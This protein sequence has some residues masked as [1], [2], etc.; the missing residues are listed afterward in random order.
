MGVSTLQR[1][2]NSKGRDSDPPEFE[3]YDFRRPMTLAREHARM[4]EMAFETFARQWS[5]QLTSRLRVVSTIVLDKLEMMSYDDYINPL[6]QHTTMALLSL[7][8]GR[9]QSILQM[10][11]ET[12]LLWIDYLLGG[13]GLERNENPRELTEIEY[14]LVT[15]LLQASMQDLGYA[16]TSVLDMSPVV[17]SI[18]YSPQFIQLV[19]AKEAVIVAQFDVTIRGHKNRASIMIPAEILV[20][21]LNKREGDDAKSAMELQEER[22]A[23]ERLNRSMHSVPVEMSVQFKPLTVAPLEITT[24]EIGQVIRLNHAVSRPLDLKVDNLTVGHGVPGNSGRQLACKVVD[25][26][27]EVA[28]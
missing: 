19:P 11:S 8:E 26:E 27:G 2:R 28:S 10:P 22:I 20:S 7:N 24:L 5:M 25:T 12:T 17:R 4:F 23:H 1:T 13:P 21:P 18:E 6:P 14:A 9:A 3:T 15:N 16:F